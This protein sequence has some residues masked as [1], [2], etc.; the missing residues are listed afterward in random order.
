MLI[1]GY[2][3]PMIKKSNVLHWQDMVDKVFYTLYAIEN[4][5]ELN[6]KS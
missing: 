2:F 4:S 1:F 5:L 3:I 6:K